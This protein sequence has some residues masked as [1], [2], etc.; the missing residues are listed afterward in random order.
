MPL[1]GGQ[2]FQCNRKAVSLTPSA[3]SRAVT[4]LTLDA[5]G[6]VAKA[7]PFDPTPYTLLG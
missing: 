1:L 4:I 3:C 2:T 7:E 5:S 6:K